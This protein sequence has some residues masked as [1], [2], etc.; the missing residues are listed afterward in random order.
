MEQ[1]HATILYEDH[2]S[3]LLMANAQ[4][5]TCHTCHIDIKK[6]LILEWVEQDLIILES[7]KTSDN[8]VDTFTKSLVNNY[9][10]DM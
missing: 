5:P 6:F 8:A 1:P 10:I 2:N 9:S 7:I 3:A 4:Q